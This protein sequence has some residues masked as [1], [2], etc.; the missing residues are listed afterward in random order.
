MHSRQNVVLLLHMRGYI[1][2]NTIKL[3]SDTYSD[4]RLCTAANNGPPRVCLD[5]M[6]TATTSSMNTVKT[7]NMRAAIYGNTAQRCND[8][9]RSWRT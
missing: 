2:H 4:A 6:L 1:S 5:V 7:S 8:L 3:K 9:K